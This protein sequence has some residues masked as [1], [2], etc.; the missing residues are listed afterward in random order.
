MVE[1]LEF[2]YRTLRD[3]YGFAPSNIRVL[4]Y[5]GTLGAVDFEP[6]GQLRR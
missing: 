4:C 3:V 5:D 1:D 6:V 2:C